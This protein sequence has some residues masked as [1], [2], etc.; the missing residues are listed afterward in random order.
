MTESDDD[1]ALVLSG[2]AKGAH[3][4]AVGDVGFYVEYF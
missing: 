1:N 3:I 4:D 2:T